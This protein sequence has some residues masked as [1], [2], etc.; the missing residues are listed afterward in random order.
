MDSLTRF[1][2]ALLVVSAL[3][4]P[5]AALAETPPASGKPAA[6]AKKET[7]GKKVHKNMKSAEKSPDHK[8][9]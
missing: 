3:G 2:R 8:M 4:L 7:K 1:G 5:A 9:H 6:A